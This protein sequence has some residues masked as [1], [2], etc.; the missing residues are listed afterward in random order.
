M[1]EWNDEKLG[2]YMDGELSP[3]EAAELEQ[4]LASDKAL[5]ARLDALRAADGATRKLYASLD[6]EP[7]PQAV[8]QMLQGD[9]AKPDNVVPFLKLGAGR[10]FR[11][12]VAI[13]ASVALVVGLL[14]INLS[15]DASGPL[16][17]GITSLE[18]VSAT[19][20]DVDTALHRMLEN[21]ASGDAIDLGSGETG[22]AILSF[23]D[24][25]GRFCRQ[26][27]ISGTDRDAHAVACRNGTAWHVEALAYTA[28]LPEGQFRTAS[29]PTPVD[30]TTAVD[31]L[32]GTADP[33]DR[34]QET[35][36]ISNG[37]STDE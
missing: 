29:E 6:A 34:E 20:I 7:V 8:L 36:V 30:I 33:L 37:W 1:Q 25:A 24:V 35:R 19:T 17:S 16:N 22:E 10:V 14:V 15:R 26:L 9:A 13:A 32:I 28:S 11:A 12:P 21:A 27:V 31:A 23:A 5:R 3:G 4:H 18:A 2:A